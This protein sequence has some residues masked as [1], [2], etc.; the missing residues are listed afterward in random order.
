[1]HVGVRPGAAAQRPSGVRYPECGR[2]QAHR[3]NAGRPPV[4]QGLGDF[5][6]FAEED[7]ERVAD[8]VVEI[9]AN[10]LPRRF[11]VDPRAQV[12]VL[13]PSHR[14]PAGAGALNQRLQQALTP[15]DP[16]S[17]PGPGGAALRGADLPGGGQG[18]PG[19]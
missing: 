1:V 18:H 4:T 15:A 12:Q 2:P 5:Y 9:V 3:V 14:G 7:P 16:A 17:R 19:P 11:G 10:R 8:L 6:L 13:C